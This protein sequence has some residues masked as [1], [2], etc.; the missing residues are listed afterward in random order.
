M[1]FVV[2]SIGEMSLE[3]RGPIIDLNMYHNFT[4]NDYIDIT[5]KN[6]CWFIKN[7]FLKDLIE[8]KKRNHIIN[9]NY[10]KQHFLQNQGD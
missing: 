4:T 1:F 9:I 3:I 2:P 10:Y 5:T 6:Y 8:M 7:K